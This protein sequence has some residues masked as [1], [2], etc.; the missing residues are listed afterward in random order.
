MISEASIDC[1]NYDEQVL[2]CVHAHQMS[3]IEPLE[4]HVNQDDTVGASLALG[5]TLHI[6]CMFSMERYCY[7]E[8]TIPGSEVSSIKR[9][10]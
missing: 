6:R 3:S 4:N 10:H 8:H 1:P 7:A 9:S 2:A 5:M